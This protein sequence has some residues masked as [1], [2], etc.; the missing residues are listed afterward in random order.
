M[1]LLK[2]VIFAYAFLILLFFILKISPDKQILD[3][4]A[5]QVHNTTASGTVE[6]VN[7]DQ[8]ITANAGDTM[9]VTF[10]L[11]KSQGIPQTL[12]FYNYHSVITVWFGEQQ[13]YTYGTKIAQKGNMIGAVYVQ[14]PI[15]A[16]SESMVCKIRLDV[17]EDNAFTNIPDFQIFHS[18]TAYQ[19]FLDYQLLTF[20]ILLT[21]FSTSIIG[22]MILF[23]TSTTVAF[24]A[25]NR[26]LT[27]HL[28]ICC[29]FFS[30]FSLYL[31]ITSGMYPLFWS[32]YV[33][34]QLE[35][36]SFITIGIPFLLLF[37][38][39]INHD[40]RFLYIAFGW[41]AGVVVTMVLH[42]T[43][44]LHLNQT[45]PVFYPAYFIIMVM[46]IVTFLRSPHN[47]KSRISSIGLLIMLFFL[48][49]DQI[50]YLIIRYANIVDSKNVTGLS[51]IGLLSFFTLIL[52]D[53]VVDFTNKQ[54]MVYTSQLEMKKLELELNNMY[55]SGLL[56]QIQPHFLY[57]SL[58]SIRS[59]I[60]TDPQRS[61]DLLY[62]FTRY[63]RSSLKLLSTHELISFH[64]ELQNIQS[65]LNIEQARL[66]NKLTVE[67]D[68]PYQDFL[69]PPLT[70]QPLVENAVKHGIFPLGKKGGH[71]II[72][73]GKNHEGYFI[74][75]RDNGVGFNVDE[76]NKQQNG[77]A[78][79]NLKYRLENLTRATLAMKS[80]KGQ[81]TTITI[82]I[83]LE[84]SKDEYRDC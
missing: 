76:R 22:L 71:L 24:T 47:I 80:A 58:S 34:S 37:Y 35:Y 69:I 16:D 50:R 18:Q 82:T 14:I 36:I 49:F 8:K 77:I 5:I 21:I 61:Y 26:Q 15:P 66:G 41:G 65:Y 9:I 3:K 67:M 78:L 23:L 70:V 39:Y 31:F 83:P 57:N 46:M 40:R 54:K 45:T 79:H 44:L 56:S 12:C 28:L 42:F 63:L 11:P 73:T 7:G 60:K 30:N 68:I 25:I 29:A 62:D 1:K 4:H 13:V 51:T 52:M 33:W 55:L 19:Y 48:T 53:T 32:G 2:R 75:I 43:N 84:D 20:V 27:T 38:N 64:D 10:S 81:G 6:T 74:F 72:R 59:M 17:K